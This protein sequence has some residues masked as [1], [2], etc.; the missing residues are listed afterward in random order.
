LGRHGR[1]AKQD[2]KQNGHYNRQRNEE[3]EKAGG[4]NGG[5]QGGQ[6][7]AGGTRGE[8]GEP[9]PKEPGGPE[10]DTRSGATRPAS[11]KQPRQG[12][13]APEVNHGHLGAASGARGD[14]PCTCGAA[15][16]VDEG[17]TGKEGAVGGQGRGVEGGKVCHGNKKPRRRAQ[18]GPLGKKKGERGRDSAKGGDGTRGS[19]GGATAAQQRKKEGK[20]MARMQEI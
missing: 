12:R 8:V 10:G 19:S 7:P 17:P 14:Y 2:A 11:R 1:G 13:K 20:Q 15:M 3:P 4:K 16:T 6:Q 5:Q 9:R 18:P